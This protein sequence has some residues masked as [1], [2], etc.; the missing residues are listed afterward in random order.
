MPRT[1]FKKRNG[2]DIEMYSP[3]PISEPDQKS[4]EVILPKSDKDEK[5]RI[6]KERRNCH[7]ISIFV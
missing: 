3:H 4:V 2:G 6:S 7:K 5:R 1:E